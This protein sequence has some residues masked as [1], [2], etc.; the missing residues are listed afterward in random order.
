MVKSAALWIVAAGFAAGLVGTVCGDEV[1]ELRKE[2]EQQY[3]AL[4][5]VQSQLL[6]IEAAQKKQADSV[7]KLE[8]NDTMTLPET[9]KWI[10]KVNLY[11]DFRYRYEHRDR[12]WKGDDDKSDRHRIRARVGL[13]GKVNDE[14]DFNLLLATG[15]DDPVSTNE[16]LGDGFASDDIWLD[17]AFLTYTPAGLE[18]LSIL[19][20]KMGTPFYAA[21]KNQLIWDGDLSP[22]GIAIQYTTALNDATGLFVNGGAL[23]VAENDADADTSLYG[24]QAGLTHSF[25]DK[26]KLTWG[27]GYFHY[28]NINGEPFVYDDEAFGNTES[29][30][31]AGTYAYDYKL[32]EVFGEYGTKLGELPIS[33]YGNYVVNTA[34]SVKEDTGWLVGTKLGKASAPGSW[35]FGYE[36]RDLEADAVLG[37]YTDSDFA[38]GGT[39]GKGHKFSVGYALAKSTTL[40]LTYFMN[41][42]LDKSPDDDYRRLQLDVNIKF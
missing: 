26:S 28:G 25:E 2:V 35:D 16:T 40:N 11:G 7:K 27:A 9:L 24:V 10:E 41:Q 36:Y 17:R 21:G 8:S 20:G 19:A 13:K 23:W 34:S 18:G 1:S 42:A 6:E 31:T 12:E 14:I 30:T 4:L 22:E 15:S 29:A 39:D 5:K 32:V 37:A 38:D 33:V 3:N